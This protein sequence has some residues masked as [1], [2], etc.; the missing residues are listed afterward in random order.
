MAKLRAV[1]VGCGNIAGGYDERIDGAQVLT[2]AKA[3]TLHPRIE[4][5]GAV[6]PDSQRLRQFGEAW[7]VPALDTR[8]EPLL[9]SA[10]ADIVS[11]CNPNS[12][13][14]DTLKKVIPFRPK[15]ILCEKPLALSSTE[16]EQMVDLCRAQG[17]A[18]VVNYIRRWDDTTLSVGRRIGDGE[19][20]SLR[21][22]RV[23]Y[24]KGV[25]HN[26]SHGLNLLSA[27]LG[28][29][30]QVWPL[31]LALIRPDGDVEASFGVSFEK[32]PLVV[33]QNH[34]AADFNLFEMDLI[35]SQG[36]VVF[37]WHS[38]AVEW[39]TSA[40]SSVVPGEKKLDAVR[41]RVPWT[42]GNSM[43]RVVEN[44]VEHLEK[45]TPLAM[46]PEDA[47]ETIR[48]CERIRNEVTK[49]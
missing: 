45:G 4:L 19:L 23:L 11:I 17:V 28:E 33:F 2:H 43:A 40:Q 44:L 3:Y 47:V 46:P 5:A 41:E 42:L 31:G 38:G 10:T 24:T 21:S 34:A 13:H 39:A 6:D 36:R 1:I 49:A 48:V 32:C 35:G 18:L 30:K 26:A 14:F 8:L 9:E 12:L 15:A 27:W 25:F 7:N 37:P 29:V 16:A 20:G 22:G